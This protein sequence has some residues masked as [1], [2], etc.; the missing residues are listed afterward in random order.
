MEAIN[1]IQ[2]KVHLE[3]GGI[4]PFLSPAG[5]KAPGLANLVDGLCFQNDYPGGLLS[6]GLDDFIN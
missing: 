2:S 6:S 1:I 5:L 3:L 4:L